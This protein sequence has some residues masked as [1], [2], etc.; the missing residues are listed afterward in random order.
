LFLHFVVLFQELVKQR[1]VDLVVPYAVAFSFLV[2][3]YQEG[4][5]LCYFFSNQAKL[6]RTGLVTLVVEGHWF[7]RKDRFTGLAHGPNVFLEPLRGGVVTK[8][9]GGGV[10]KYEVRV[11]D[12]DTDDIVDKAT[13]IDICPN[14]SDTDNVT[15]RRN[16]ASGIVA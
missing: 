5:N 1:R 16:T 4:I 8:L 10:N 15:G 7:K 2:Q 9:A 12:S 14:T 11:C 3:R 6:R 13:V